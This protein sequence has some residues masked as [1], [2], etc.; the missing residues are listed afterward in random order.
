MWKIIPQ[1]PNYMVNERGEVFSLHSKKVLRPSKSNGYCKVIL[2][3][4]GGRHTLS[5]HRLVADAFVENPY[6]LPCVNHKDENKFNNIA[7]NL[8]WCTYKYNNTYRNR[9]FKAGKK[10]QKRVFQLDDS[11]N[12]IKAFDSAREASKATGIRE[13]HIARAARGERKTCKG[14]RWVWSEQKFS[15][16]FN[17]GVEK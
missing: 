4:D 9:H 12:V 2:M 13:E 11:G 6:N 14:Y 17:Q 5:V 3:K 16:V 8:E 1:Y 10:L 7:S 15:S